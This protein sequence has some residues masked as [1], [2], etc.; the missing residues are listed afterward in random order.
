MPNS[1]HVYN[2]H[3]GEIDL[4]DQQV[5]VYRVRIR[6]KKWWWP[7]FAW[8]INAKVVNAWFQY[9]KKEPNMSLLDFSRHIV[10]S[11]SKT[12]GEAKKQ[13][14][15]KISPFSSVMD[16]IRFNGKQ[17]W[18]ARGDQVH[19]RCKQCGMRTRH[20]CKMCNLPMHPECMETFHTKQ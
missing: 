1:I 5:L 10:I 6:S 14:G 15:P 4:F 12:Y 17:Q 19:C 13:P 3:I 8:S 9:R 20:M 18:T 16:E 2:K 7:L 11:I